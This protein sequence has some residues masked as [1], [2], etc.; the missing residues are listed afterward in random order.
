M[1]N[2]QQRLEVLIQNVHLFISIHLVIHAVAFVH[3]LICANLP[4]TRGKKKTPGMGVMDNMGVTKRK[5]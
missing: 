1:G 3:F 2:K 5:Y 4:D